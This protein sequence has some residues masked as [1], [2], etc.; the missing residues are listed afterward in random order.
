MKDNKQKSI[1]EKLGI[2]KWFSKGTVICEN[3]SE[4][5]S[6]SV[7]DTALSFGGFSEEKKCAN[8]Q[9]LA[10]APEMLEAMIYDEQLH[11]QETGRNTERIKI[12]EK[13]CYPKKWEQIKELIE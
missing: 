10:A 6:V 4:G 1:I 3:V 11:E 8:A 5:C 7:A 2:N 9:L 13:A 12:I